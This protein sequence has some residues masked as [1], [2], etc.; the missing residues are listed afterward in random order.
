LEDIEKMIDLALKKSEELR[1][2]L[3]WG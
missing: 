1:K 2:Y 3:K